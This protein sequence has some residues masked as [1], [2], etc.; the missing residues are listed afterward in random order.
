MNIK[1]LLYSMLQENTGKALCDSGDA[2]GRHWQS[3]QGKDFEKDPEVELDGEIKAGVNVTEDVMLSVSTYHL[4]Y[5][6]LSLDDLC[7]EFNSGLGD[8]NIQL[9]DYARYGDGDDAV[10]VQEFLNKHDLTYA[11][12]LFNTYNGE[13]LGD[14]TLQGVFLES[15]DGT[16]YLFLQIHNGCDVRGGYTGAKMFVC[17]NNYLDTHAC[18]DISYVLNGELVKIQS[19]TYYNGYSLKTEEGKDVIIPEGATNIS[20]RA[21]IL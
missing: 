15:G 8:F 6:A 4:L 21:W 9:C 18:L 17:E 12:E 5:N 2:Y 10:R 13:W 11:G 19:D 16:Y 20:W 14:Q 3:N 1:E 7:Q